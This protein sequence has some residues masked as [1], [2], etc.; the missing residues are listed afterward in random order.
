MEPDHEPWKL[1]KDVAV[2]I[3]GIKTKTQHVQN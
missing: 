2:V 1:F 3:F